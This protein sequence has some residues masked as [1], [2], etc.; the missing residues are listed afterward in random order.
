MGESRKATV[1]ASGIG[2]YLL[3]GVLKGK[4]REFITVRKEWGEGGVRGVERERE[5]WGRGRRVTEIL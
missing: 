4:G 3:G 5:I 2:G 1:K